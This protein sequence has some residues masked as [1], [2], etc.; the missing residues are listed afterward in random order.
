MHRGL[1]LIWMKGIHYAQ[2]KFMYQSIPAVNI[3]QA[4]LFEIFWNIKIPI[5]RAKNLVWKIPEAQSLGQIKKASFSRD[6]SYHT[7]ILHLHFNTKRHFK[8]TFWVSWATRVGQFG[9]WK[10]FQRAWSIFYDFF[11]LFWILIMNDVKAILSFEFTRLEV[12]RT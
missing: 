5:P 11:L 2:L 4:D 1:L 9:S 8:H 12:W 10:F 7:N 6:D 3:P